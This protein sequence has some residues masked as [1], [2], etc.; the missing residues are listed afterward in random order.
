MASYH[1]SR[2]A[3]RLCRPDRTRF[4][5]GVPADVSNVHVIQVLYSGSERASER[6]SRPSSCACVVHPACSALCGARC[7]PC[8]WLGTATKTYSQ[9]G[10]ENGQHLDRALPSRQSH[11]CCCSR[12]MPLYLVVS[13]LVADAVLLPLLLLRLK[14]S[15]RRLETTYYIYARWVWRRVY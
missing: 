15:V 11:Y 3:I 7:A 4:H 8:A 6:A 13:P 9:A 10:G 12:N 14:G 1:A 2:V 5:R